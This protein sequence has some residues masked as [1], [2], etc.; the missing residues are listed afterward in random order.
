MSFER[1][2]PKYVLRQAQ[3]LALGLGLLLI[4]GCFP[5]ADGIVIE[6]PDLSSERLLVGVVFISPESELQVAQI[7]ETRTLLEPESNHKPIE[8]ATVITRTEEDATAN[9]FRFDNSRGF[10]TSPS[11]IL[12]GRTYSLSV[13]YQD[14]SLRGTCKIPQQVGDVDVVQLYISNEESSN[15]EGIPDN[16]EDIPEWNVK[17]NIQDHPEENSYHLSLSIVTTAPLR[18]IEKYLPTTHLDIPRHSPLDTILTIRSFLTDWNDTDVLI[19]DQG[20]EGQ[21]L[22]EDIE[23]HNS[24]DLI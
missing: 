21:F 17:M 23:I 5:D 6:N 8:S 19:K 18:L 1:I 3:L 22:R 24:Y 9:V 7:S 13:Q 2:C 12:E 15:I 16:A 11:P 10:Y 14:R 20:R 4:S